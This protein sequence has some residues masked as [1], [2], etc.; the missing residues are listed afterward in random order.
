MFLRRRKEEKEGKW[1][2]RSFPYQH[3]RSFLFIF[4][5]RL[6]FAKAE[7][8]SDQINTFIGKRSGCSC[9]HIVKARRVL[10]PSLNFI[11]S[12]IGLRLRGEGVCEMKWHRS[13]FAHNDPRRPIKRY[14]QIPLLPRFFKYR[15]SV[16]SRNQTSIFLFYVVHLD[17]RGTFRLVNLA[18]VET[19]F[20]GSF[21]LLK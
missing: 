12:L 15:F 17:L 20:C 2:H 13:V 5:D 18:L 8:R 7:Q 19:H 10:Y 16:H 6:F 21:M 9:W 11:W 4:L 3:R 1:K 14:E